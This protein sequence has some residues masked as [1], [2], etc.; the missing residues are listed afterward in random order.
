MTIIQ[1]NTY[2]QRRRHG[3]NIEGARHTI[4]G[5]KPMILSPLLSKISNI[6]GAAAPSAPPMAPPLTP[7]KGVTLLKNPLTRGWVG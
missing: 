5:A 1:R 7:T 4:G 6:E 2:W 3:K